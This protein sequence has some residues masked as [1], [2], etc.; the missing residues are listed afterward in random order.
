M[1]NSVQLH[2]SGWPKH[3]LSASMAPPAP[4]SCAERVCAFCHSC[5]ALAS[6]HL[7]T[8]CTRVG[9]VVAN[10]TTTSMAVPVWLA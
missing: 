7:E 10:Y 4:A 1:M 8:T 3:A 6:S 5:I 9:H 2:D